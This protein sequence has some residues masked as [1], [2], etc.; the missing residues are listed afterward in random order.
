MQK[1]KRILAFDFGA[2]S[3]R[4]MLGVFDG[5]R[6]ELSEIHRFSNDPVLLGGTLY[7]DTLRLFHEIK[8][9]LVKAKLAGGFDSVGINTWGVDFGLLDKDGVLLENGVNY[10]D[11]RTEGMINSASKLIDLDELYKKTGNQIMEINTAFQL[12]SLKEQRPELLDR[13]DA[14]LM[15]PDL[16]NFFLTGVKKTEY[17]IASTTQ[18]AD[19]DK[20]DWNREVIDELG[21]NRSL[22]GEIVPSGTVIGKLSDDL[23]QELGLSKVPVVAVCGH[24]TQ[25]AVV[26]VPTGEKDFIFVSCGTWSLFGTETDKPIINDKAYELNLTNE[27]GFGGTTNI[28]KNIIGLWLIQ[29]SRR[30]WQREGKDYSFADL[31]KLAL[32]SEPFKCFIDPDYPTLTPPGDLPKRIQ[33]F[34]RETGQYVPQTVGEIVRCIYESLSLKYRYAFDQIREL[35]EKEYKIINIVGGGTKD[36]LLCQMTANSC[37]TPVTAGPVEATVYGNIAVQLMSDGSIPD[38]KTARS[39]IARSDKVK[40]FEPQS[41]QIESFDKAYKDFKKIIKIK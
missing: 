40:R 11:K 38:V 1:I 27:G 2:S 37:G 13:A 20:R 9:G 12:L 26:S 4:A 10:R 32:D 34:C 33:E 36:G 3:G 8:Q 21:L 7:W 28:L 29:E 41:G 23:C 22:F 5:N 31:E 24:D 15:T 16:F 18:L 14:M 35:T 19:P 17:S 30:Q 25:N 6:I 39:I